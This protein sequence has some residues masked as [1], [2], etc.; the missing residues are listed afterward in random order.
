MYSSNHTLITYYIHVN[1][2]VDILVFEFNPLR[3]AFKPFSNFQSLTKV[4]CLE[5][6]WVF[7]CLQFEASQ[8]GQIYF[9]VWFPSTL[10]LLQ[11]R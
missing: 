11:V 2:L 6:L 9:S 3:A 4:L 7:V 10:K 8:T 1:Y 5:D